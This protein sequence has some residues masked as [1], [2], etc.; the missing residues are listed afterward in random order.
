MM[1]SLSGL[2]VLYKADISAHALQGLLCAWQP[3]GVATHPLWGYILGHL[4]FP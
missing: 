2:G 3:G 4:G 1:V